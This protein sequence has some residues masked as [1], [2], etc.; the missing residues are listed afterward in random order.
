MKGELDNTAAIVYNEIGYPP[1][2]TEVIMKYL[3]KILAFCIMLAI[4]CSATVGVCGEGVIFKIYIDEYGQWV[5]SMPDDRF[6]ILNDWLINTPYWAIDAFSPGFSSSNLMNHPFANGR[7]IDFEITP[8]TGFKQ[9]VIVADIPDEVRGVYN[10]FI[11]TGKKTESE[12]KVEVTNLVRKNTTITFDYSAYITLPTR[13]DEH[14]GSPTYATDYDVKLYAVTSDKQTGEIIRYDLVDTLGFFGPKHCTYT[15]EDIDSPIKYEPD[16]LFQTK[17][18]FP[19]NYDPEKHEYGFCLI[20][21]TRH[22]YVDEPY[23]GKIAM[24]NYTKVD[25]PELILLG[26]IDGNGAVT[27]AD[28]SRFERILSGS[29]GELNIRADVNDDGKIET[30]DYSALCKKLARGVK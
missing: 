25:V 28:I 30:K 26:D 19:G 12:A 2:F 18:N 6:K 24:Y 15:I 23:Y 27:A 8:S 29:S 1:L 7:T 20:A 14:L 4:L 16:R 3:K 17:I 5:V 11:N 22:K 21:Y 10:E 9:T 13:E